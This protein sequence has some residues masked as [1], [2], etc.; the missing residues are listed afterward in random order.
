MRVAQDHILEQLWG[1]MSPA[2]RPAGGTLNDFWLT[3]AEQ[4]AC[5]RDTPATQHFR[6]RT[7][8]EDA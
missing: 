4:D 2:L 3:C 1:T 5:C 6:I 7:P 8:I